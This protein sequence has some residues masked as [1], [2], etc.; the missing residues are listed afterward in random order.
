M[1]FTFSAMSAGICAAAGI[2]NA[3]TKR[4]AET[5]VR[6]LRCSSMLLPLWRRHIGRVFVSFLE[7]RTHRPTTKPRLVI[8]HAAGPAASSASYRDRGFSRRAFS[9][10]TIF[11]DIVVSIFRN[12]G[13][14]GGIAALLP[15][16]RAFVD[17]REFELFDGVDGFVPTG[18]QSR[19]C[20][21]QDR[22]ENR[23]PC[24]NSPTVVISASPSFSG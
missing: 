20:H 15:L 13:R 14:F 5:D 11:I 19:Q 17:L 8:L 21:Q 22:A 3:A 10:L 16:R 1:A 7:F 24:R 12:L 6:T 4:I 2:A 18:G 9:L 23:Y